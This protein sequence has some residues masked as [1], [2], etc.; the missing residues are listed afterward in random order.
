MTTTAN[1]DVAQRI[2]DILKDPGNMAFA[3]FLIFLAASRNH[4]TKY[5]RRYSVPAAGALLMYQY[6][7]RNPSEQGF[8]V[9][10][11]QEMVMLQDSLLTFLLPIFQMGSMK[12]NKLLNRILGDIL[13]VIIMSGTIKGVNEVFSLNPISLLKFVKDF[14]YD[15]VKPLPYHK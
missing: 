6:T 2:K 12:N 3:S 8:Y 10:S 11:N 13:G 14:A 15:M 4:Y 1:T 9:S 5:I 7:R